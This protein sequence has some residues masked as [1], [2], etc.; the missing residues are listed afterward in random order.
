MNRTAK[1]ACKQATIVV[2]GDPVTLGVCH[3]ANCRRRTGSAFG[4]SAYFEK[5]QVLSRSGE[6]K[7]FAFHHS[8]QKHDQERYF[9]VHCGTT[10]FWH[11]SSLPQLVGVAGG[12]FDEEPLGE[13]AES[14]AHYQKLPWVSLPTTW[15]CSN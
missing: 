8:E 3:C 14:Y 9:C 6:T 13:P 1:C 11:I 12:C 2:T 5:E 15:S 10:L 7:R 4:I